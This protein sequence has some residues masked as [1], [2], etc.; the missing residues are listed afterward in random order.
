MAPFAIGSESLPF[1]V[2]GERCS[3]AAGQRS[4]TA[5]TTRFPAPS[6]RRPRVP[7]RDARAPAVV[8]RPAAGPSAWRCSA[9]RSSSARA[10]STAP[11]T[12]SRS[13]PCAGAARR[14][15][16]DRGLGPHHGPAAVR[17]RADADRYLPGGAE[18]GGAVALRALG[19]GELLPRDAVGSTGRPPLI[20]LPL[21]LDAGRVPAAVRVGSS[22]DVWAPSRR[23]GSAEPAGRPEAELLLSDVPVL[24]SGRSAGALGGGLRQVV[25]GVPENDEPRMA[26]IVAQA[27]PRSAPAGP[28]A[29]VSGVAQG[30]VAVLLLAAGAASWEEQALERLAA[31]GTARAA[32]AVPRPHR[33]ARDRRAGERA[34]AVVSDQLPG[35]DADSLDRLNQAGVRTVVVTAPA[36]GSGAPGGRA[37]RPLPAASAWVPPGSRRRGGRHA[38]ASTCSPPPTRSVRSRRRAGRPRRL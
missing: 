35:L 4:W 29:G 22:V 10:S 9:A 7:G 5:C 3:P 37:G 34:V 32:Q 15:A 8:A 24:S 20:E 36:A 33:P 6:T 30:R 14:R 25:V 1:F 11:T 19:A 12:R 2:C 16:G 26:R 17:R 13:W 28:A 21:T 38:A 31:P 23:R 18:L 27:A